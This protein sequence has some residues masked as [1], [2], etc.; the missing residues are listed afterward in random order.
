MCVSRLK[1]EGSISWLTYE[2]TDFDANFGYEPTINCCWGKLYVTT[3]ILHH[4]QLAFYE[5]AG[6]PVPQENLSLVEQAVQP[7]ADSDANFTVSG[8]KGNLG[9]STRA[10]DRI[11]LI[12]RNNSRCLR[13]E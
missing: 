1:L 5:Q 7:V 6:R 12:L 4:S 3:E 13:K 2:C 10:P 8:V 9:R 11:A